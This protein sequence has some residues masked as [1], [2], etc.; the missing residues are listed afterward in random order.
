MKHPKNYD[1]TPEIRRRMSKVRLK[2][3]RAESI[4]AK[5]LWHEGYRY[6]KII[7]NYQGRQI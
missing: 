6:R 4:L 1:S 7:K 3:G 5:R 2:N